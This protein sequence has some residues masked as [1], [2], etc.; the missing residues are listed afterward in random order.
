MEEAAGVPGPHQAYGNLGEWPLGHPWPCL[1]VWTRQLPQ[2]LGPCPQGAP[3]VQ[4]EEGALYLGTHLPQALE[5]KESQG[6]VLQGA[7]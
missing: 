6:V 1:Q 3:S 2:G 5:G 4:K 7:G